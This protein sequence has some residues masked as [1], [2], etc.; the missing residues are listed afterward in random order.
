MRLAVCLSGQVRTWK[1]T[2]Q[3]CLRMFS[4]NKENQIDFYIHAWSNDSYSCDNTAEVQGIWEGK[5]EQLVNEL[6]K[7]YDPVRVEVENNNYCPD[8]KKDAESYFWRFECMYYSMARAIGFAAN[9]IRRKGLNYYDSV[10]WTRFDLGF[11]SKVSEQCICSPYCIK[12]TSDPFVHK[13]VIDHNI[14]TGMIVRDVFFT[15][16]PTTALVFSDIFHWYNQTKPLH[17]FW[18]SE[19]TDQYGRSMV[20]PVESV[21]I[22][23]VG[24]KRLMWEEPYSMHE[25]IVR[26]G[27]EA[28]KID[29]LNDEEKYLASRISDIPF[30]CPELEKWIVLE[31][32]KGNVR[33]V[34]DYLV[35][36]TTQ[37]IDS[38]FWQRYKSSKLV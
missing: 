34:D 12:F 17:T 10:I 9:T 30:L 2:F 28:V 31:Y 14:L 16:H 20:V 13:E 4:Q 22:Q 23:Y 5:E 21:P 36:G 37:R 35:Y 6:K 25:F 3:D 27:V 26:S 29:L 7:A 1:T 33:F 32:R 38:S 18:E 8:I 15:M 24:T 19:R 11:T